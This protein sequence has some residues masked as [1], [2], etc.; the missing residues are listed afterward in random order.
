MAEHLRRAGFAIATAA[1]GRDGI[2]RFLELSPQAIIVRD[3][4]PGLDGWDTARRV[5]EMSDVPIVF[6]ADRR[7]VFAMERALHLG[8][9][10]VTPPWTWPRVAAKLSAL[11]RRRRDDGDAALSYDD[12]KL[13]VDFARRE[14]RRHGEPVHLTDTEFKLLSCLLRRPNRVLTYDELLNQVWGHTH[15]GARSHVSLYVRYLRKKLEDDPSNPAYFL[16]EWG[17]GYSFRPRQ[18]IPE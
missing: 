4:M 14:V 17:V 16:T 1:N 6:V 5:R 15:F 10:Y 12:G 3:A 2:R 13:S 11:L 7:D 9:D 18:S 8:D